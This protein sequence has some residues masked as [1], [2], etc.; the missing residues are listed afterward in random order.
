MLDL[1]LTA[2]RKA[3]VLAPSASN[4]VLSLHADVLLELQ[5][6]RRL[7]AEKV[8]DELQFLCCDRHMCAIFFT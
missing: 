3:V 1:F 2:V 5:V 8:G 6:I 7:N 4:R